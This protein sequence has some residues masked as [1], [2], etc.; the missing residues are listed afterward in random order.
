MC[1]CAGMDVCTAR[2][3]IHRVMRAGV[4]FGLCS[5]SGACIS[6]GGAGTQQDRSKIS[7]SLSVAS[8]P[9]R[10]AGVTPSATAHARHR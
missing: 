10:T 8:E 9:V 7:G 4:T 2:G 6:P 1:K 5:S 3:G